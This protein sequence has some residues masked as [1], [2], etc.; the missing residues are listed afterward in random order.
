MI[1]LNEG[2]VYVCLWEKD[3]TICQIFTVLLLFSVRLVIAFLYRL[4]FYT[5]NKVLLCDQK[6]HFILNL[7]W[8]LIF[9]L[10]FWQIHLVQDKSSK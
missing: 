3:L 1:F 9:M 6:I 4:F 7:V 5:E 8:I 2:Y 10:V